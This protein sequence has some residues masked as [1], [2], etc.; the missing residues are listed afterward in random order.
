MGRGNTQD[1]MPALGMAIMFVS[2]H[3]IIDSS[4]HREGH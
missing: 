4:R 1:E 2:V 3:M